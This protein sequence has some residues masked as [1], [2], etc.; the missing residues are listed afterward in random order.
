MLSNSKKRTWQTYIST[1]VDKQSL[2]FNAVGGNLLGACEKEF[3]IF[4][5]KNSFKGAILLFG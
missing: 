1:G 5:E 4:E 3:P 2:G